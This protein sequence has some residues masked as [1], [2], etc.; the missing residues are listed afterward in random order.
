MSN[1]SHRVPALHALIGCAP[2]GIQ[3]HTPEFA[4]CAQSA[5]ADLAVSDGAKALAMTAIDLLLDDGLRARAQAA[6]AA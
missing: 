6:H 3:I 1:V 4:V 5:A 2:R